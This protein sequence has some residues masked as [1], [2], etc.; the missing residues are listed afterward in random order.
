MISNKGV[1]QSQYPFF[2]LK[3]IPAY[4]AS[5]SIDLRRIDRC[6]APAHQS[7]LPASSPNFWII[8]KARLGNR[9]LCHE[10]RTA[11]LK[12]LDRSLISTDLLGNL[13]DLLL[14]KSDQRTDIPASSQT[15]LVAARDCIVWLAT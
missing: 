1:L 2:M 3:I 4:Y 11:V 8:F 14:V 7:S 10:D 6:P 5:T 15:S 9:M 13:N 12:R